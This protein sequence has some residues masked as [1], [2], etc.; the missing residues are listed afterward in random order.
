MESLWSYIMCSTSPIFLVWCLIMFRGHDGGKTGGRGREKFNSI[1]FAHSPYPKTVV[2]ERSGSSSVVTLSVQ[3]RPGSIWPV[4]NCNM[5]MVICT[6]WWRFCTPIGS[7]SCPKADPAHVQHVHHCC[8][9]PLPLWLSSSCPVPSS[10]CLFSPPCS[11][12]SWLCFFLS[13]S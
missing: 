4:T 12:L 11:V 5:L 7:S 3:L 2:S 1:A 10:F 6:D 13:C 9:F 8:P